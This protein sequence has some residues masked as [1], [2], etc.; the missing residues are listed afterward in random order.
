MQG[1]PRHDVSQ[2]IHPTSKCTALTWHPEKILLATG[3]ENG[4]VYVWFDGHREFVQVSAPHKAAIT[5]VE[6]S[7]QGGRMV[8]ADT[9]GLLT[10]WRCDGQY[11]FLTIF[12]HD[13]REVFK[14]IT[15]RRT[16]CSEAREEMFNLAKA[17]VAGDETALD[18]LTNWRPRTAARSVT[19]NADVKDN[20]C[21]FAG[22]Q[23]GVLYYVNQGG[24][25]TEIQTGQTAPISQM[26][27]HP[28]K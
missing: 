16:I 2:P 8:T 14:Y 3:W 6:F 19:H 12:T 7:E 23:A 21:F 5:L 10:G 17:A 18:T 1:E 13:L 20:Y 9:M 28:K 25:C 15:F 24:T 4:D 11:Q 27:W 26:L 22:T